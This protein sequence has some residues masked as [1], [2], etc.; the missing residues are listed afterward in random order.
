[1]A[2]FP[3][4]FLLSFVIRYGFWDE[5]VERSVE[6]KEWKR[7]RR[8]MIVRGGGGERWRR[9]KRGGKKKRNYFEMNKQQS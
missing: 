4:S 9:G 7:K 3:F 6:E 8:R 2:P 1:M 5:R